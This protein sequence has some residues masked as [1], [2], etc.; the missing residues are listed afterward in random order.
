MTPS[1]HLWL[2]P[3]LCFL[4]FALNLLGGRRW[5]QRVAGWIGV[6][7]PAAAFADALWVAS[8]W[9][10]FALP[11]IE[12]H[13]RWIVAGPLAAPFG[14]Q[15]DPLSLVMLLVVSGV[16]LVIHVYSLGYMAHE[17]GFYRFFALMNL[18]LFFMLLLVLAD[19]FLL[20]FIGWEGVGFASYALIGFFFH[21]DSAAAAG[22]KAF[23]VNRIGD[24]GF[25]IGLFLMFQH[26]H[27]FDFT[28][29]FAQVRQLPVEHAWSGPLTV[30]AILLF[31]GATGKSAQL[32]LY[33]WLPDA[34]EG[35]TP[36][37][38]LIH[39]ATMVT[40]G[41][42]M[43][44]RSAAIY[45]RA[46]LALDVVL[47][48]GALTAIFAASIGLLQR[49][50]KKVLA[51]STISQ[52]GYMFMACGAMVYGAG[53]FHLVTHAFFKGLLF[54][55]AGGAIHAISGEQDMFRIRERVPD[56]LK[57]YAPI[58]FWTFLIATCSISGIPGFAGFFSKD[59]IL[60]EV[61]AGPRPNAG[62]WVVGTVAAGL[63]AFY[64]F[65]ALFVTFWP[66]PARATA[67]G[68]T[69]G[70]VHPTGEEPRGAV[71]HAI[72]AA[73]FTAGQGLEQPAHP[74]PQAPAPP[75]EAPRVMTVPMIILAVLSAIGGYIGL[76]NR[77]EN[78]LAPVF[79]TGVVPPAH[80]AAM[81]EGGVMGISIAVALAGLA[82][83]WYFYLARPQAAARAKQ[84]LP[85]L[86]A[87]VYNK[88]WVDELY[89]ALFTRPLAWVSRVI[90][91]RVVDDGVIDGSVAAVAGL[92]RASGA[93]ARRQISGNIRSYAGWIGIGAVVAIFYMLVAR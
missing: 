81:S 80:A 50:I 40:A 46:P 29:V 32:P 27:G 82:L 25:L 57:K 45:D 52:L 74:Q 16:G 34:M 17:G 78:F 7:F 36:V 35:P 88:Y 10:R 24:M 66:D 69:S 3:V 76:G 9:G 87:A 19:N 65:R 75:H 30:I 86:W 49:D 56:G 60:Y 55:A 31:I 85:H 72:D 44:A 22:S 5:P 90:L 39:A 93:G 26:F 84:A 37:S 2:I 92:S 38:A 67:G 83:A 59:K 15:L 70:V 63:T 91:W 79:Q 51:Y 20:M 11:Y 8:R 48:V 23:I 28:R 89:A 73:S 42:Y 61:L 14:F 71:T 64:M 47:A 54:L 77:F 13:G 21:K 12:T 43:V 58:T 41:V 68:A 33:V 18:F 4:G 6:L 1:L 62:W 53:I